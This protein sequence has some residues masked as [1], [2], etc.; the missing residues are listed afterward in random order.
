ME[1][2]VMTHAVLPEH[3]VRE[4]LG[5]KNYNAMYRFVNMGILSQKDITWLSEIWYYGYTLLE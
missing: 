3:I 4:K 2:H 1:S 5:V